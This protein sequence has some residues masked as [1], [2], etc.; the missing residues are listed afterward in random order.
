MDKHKL[1]GLPLFKSL[2]KRELE[3]IGSVTDEVD[4][5]EGKMLLH[6]GDFAHEFMVVLEGRAEV[7]RDEEPVAEIGPGDFLGEVAALDKS[8]RNA[9]VIARSPMRLVVMTDYDMRHIARDMPGLDDQL[10]TAAS[11]HCPLTTS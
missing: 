7:V 5:D 8:Q 11:E 6:E 1:E 9:T 2:G 4:V 10:R 3:R